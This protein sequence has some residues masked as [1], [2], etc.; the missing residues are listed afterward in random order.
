[1]NQ[2]F[3]HLKLQNQYSNKYDVLF[4]T[5]KNYIIR[6]YI[7]LIIMCYV[8]CINT[9]TLFTIYTTSRI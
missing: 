9:N 8:L 2:L 4:L 5:Y 1:M 7:L 6:Y 3:E